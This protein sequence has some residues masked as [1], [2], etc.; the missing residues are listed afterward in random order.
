MKSIVCYTPSHIHFSVVYFWK[1]NFWVAKVFFSNFYEWSSNDLRMIQIIRMNFHSNVDFE[2]SFGND[3][4]FEWFLWQIIRMMNHLRMIFIRNH[5][6][7]DKSFGNDLKTVKKTFHL[8]SIRLRPTCEVFTASRFWKP[9][10]HW[11]NVDVCVIL[12]FSVWTNIKP[13]KILEKRTS[14]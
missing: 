6:S 11:C 8:H 13:N 5:S 14:V 4:S 10:K 1:S 2:K 12:W 3:L 9:C 7:N